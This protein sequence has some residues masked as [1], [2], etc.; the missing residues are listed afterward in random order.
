MSDDFFDKIDKQLGAEKTTA[1]TARTHADTAK[2]FSKQVIKRVRPVADDYA[3]KLKARGIDAESAGHDD[4][5]AFKLLYADG[6]GVEMS[7]G[8]NHK[9]GR[10]ALSKHYRDDKG[11]YKTMDES[12]G[13]EKW[14]D[15]YYEVKLKEF[16]EEFMA[17]APKHGGALKR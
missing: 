16:I 3:A 14:K 17:V 4:Y 8:V 13:E 6:D 15:T 10:L 12:F 11:P 7:F 1:E 9:N 2:A 5:I